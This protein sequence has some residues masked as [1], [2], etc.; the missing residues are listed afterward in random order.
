MCYLPE[1]DVL[2]KIGPDDFK[3]VLM[4]LCGPEA[5][6]EWTRLLESIKPLSGAA[7]ALPPAALRADPAVALTV[8]R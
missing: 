4:K 5:V 7:M 8:L 3:D 2:S 6:E 1:G